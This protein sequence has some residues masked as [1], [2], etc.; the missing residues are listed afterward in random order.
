MTAFATVPEQQEAKRL[1]TAALALNPLVPSRPLAEMLV[2][3][4]LPS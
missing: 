1:L 2:D 3:A 4:L